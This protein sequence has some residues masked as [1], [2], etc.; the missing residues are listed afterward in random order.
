MVSNNLLGGFVDVESDEHRDRRM[1]LNEHQK[2]YKR[3]HCH[4]LNGTIIK[5]NRRPRLGVCELCGRLC[6][7]LGEM[8]DYH[9]WD[10]SD[11]DTGIWLCRICHHFAERVDHDY[12]D[13]YL[14]LKDNIIA[15][16]HK[17]QL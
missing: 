14:I 17:P 3:Q 2:T 1:T 7:K 8:L 5:V 13:R 11:L 10:D 12:L 9:H 15:D 6:G 16:S 4:V